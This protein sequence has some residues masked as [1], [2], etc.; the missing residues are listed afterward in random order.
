VGGENRGDPS[1]LWGW[2]NYVQ[3]GGFI[4]SCYFLDRYI[5]H[6]ST[7]GNVAMAQMAVNAIA[8]YFMIS[9]CI[10]GAI[11]AVLILVGCC[12]C[13]CAPYVIVGR[14]LLY[15]NE[16]NTTT[17]TTATAAWT[18]EQG[19]EQQR[20]PPRPLTRQ[21]T[22]RFGHN[23]LNRAASFVLP[24]HNPTEEICSIC[25]EAFT[26]TDQ[27][28]VLGCRHLFHPTCID[29]WLAAHNTCPNCRAV[30]NQV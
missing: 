17:T 23:I 6:D 24:M 19:T 10:I 29:P 5:K 3:L 28:K 9:L 7:Y 13:C 4:T 25:T 1:T 12:I 22:V 26:A 27:W 16:S 15:G 2:L 8:I 30:V 20:H 11:F 21:N 18:A 14:Q